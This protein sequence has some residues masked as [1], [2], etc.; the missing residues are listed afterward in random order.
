MLTTSVK[1]SDTTQKDFLELI[2][3]QSDQKIWQKYFRENLK[4]V[5]EPLTCL[6]TISVLRRG[7]LDI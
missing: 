6:L 7:F 2:F 4:T 5:S 3:F 1:I